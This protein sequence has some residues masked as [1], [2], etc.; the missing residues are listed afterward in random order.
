MEISNLFMI[1]WI[2]SKKLELVRSRSEKA[3]DGE[4]MASGSS[5]VSTNNE[6]VF[7]KCSSVVASYLYSLYISYI[8]FPL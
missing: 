3:D 5:D 2:Q 8:V 4:N 1:K 7:D 6:S